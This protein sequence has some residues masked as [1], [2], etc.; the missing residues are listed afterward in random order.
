MVMRSFLL[1][2]AVFLF[3]IG[4][5]TDAYA[6]C[7]TCKN[8]C[9]KCNETIEDEAELTRDHTE[10]EIIQHEDFI[11]NT[12][13]RDNIRPA[14]MRM[15]NQIVASAYMQLGMIGGFF[16]AKHQL[17]VQRLL[18]RKY[19]EALNEFRPDPSL[20]QVATFSSSLPSTERLMRVNHTL[21]AE[22]MLDHQTGAR[23]TIAEKGQ[24]MNLRSR[25]NQFKSTYCSTEDMAGNLGGIEGTLCG[26]E[27]SV[28]PA[29]INND[30]DYT[31]L[32][33]FPA[34]LDINLTDQTMT[35][36]EE[37]VTALANNLFAYDLH[38][39]FSARDL[40]Y[41]QQN[42]SLT[43]PQEK[44]LEIRSLLA[45]RQIAENSF[46]SIAAMKSRGSGVADDYF[47]Q[48]LMNLGLNQEAIDRLVTENPSYNAQM[49]IMTKKLYQ[50]PNFITGLVKRP[51]GVK[52]QLASMNAISLMQQRDAYNSMLRQEMS[53]AVILEKLVGEHIRQTL[54]DQI[55]GA[56][57]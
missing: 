15:T 57:Q 17:E 56:I 13:F 11:L 35:P 16:D 51:E 27:A 50:D 44:Y 12:F 30:I 34:T 18:D 4:S 29:R 2:I 8:L 1:V 28:F 10:R 32:M 41:S 52:R 20:C 26:P 37:D 45:K 46:F 19:T 14:M 5:L 39:R 21:F 7:G 54:D 23:G 53:M 22:R 40:L 36:D 47:R 3:T 48:M 25:L 38:S 33:D 55:Q 43:D 9:D 6:S 31:K 24:F 49:E 42:Q